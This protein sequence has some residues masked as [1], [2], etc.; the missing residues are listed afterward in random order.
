MGTVVLGVEE[1]LGKENVKYGIKPIP[2]VGDY[3]ELQVSF[4]PDRF[5]AAAVVAAV[6]DTMEQNP[7]PRYPGLVRVVYVP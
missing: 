3:S 1:R 2:G 4:D 7:D 5:D 6:Q